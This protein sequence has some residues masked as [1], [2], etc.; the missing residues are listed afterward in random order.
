MGTKNNPGDFDCYEN[1]DDDE[2]MFVLLGRDPL[3]AD[4][5]RLWAERRA[6]TR[7]E[8]N[9]TAEARTC[10]DV[11]EW[12]H[13]ALAKCVHCFRTIRWDETYHERNRSL[14]ESYRGAWVHNDGEPWS[15]GSYGEHKAVPV[16]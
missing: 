2:P 6:A 15:N 14:G 16:R 4:L 8:D 7:G 10:A 5:V 9:K 13:G 12:W 3:A 11:M 1:A